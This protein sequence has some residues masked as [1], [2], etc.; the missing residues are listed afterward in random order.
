MFVEKGLPCCRPSACFI[1]MEICLCKSTKLGFTR[2]R[3]C[4]AAHMCIGA[5]RQVARLCERFRLVDWKMLPLH[6]VLSVWISS[7]CVV[8]RWC[9]D[10]SSSSITKGLKWFVPPTTNIK[11]DFC[12]EVQY[13]YFQID[14]TTWIEFI[15]CRRAI[16][17]R[18][19]AIQNRSI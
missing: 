16:L 7:S 18:F 14:K 3:H 2:E 6:T 5:V 13:I 1:S 4:K 17:P 19:P 8:L 15:K 11:Q 10:K 12:L 9:L